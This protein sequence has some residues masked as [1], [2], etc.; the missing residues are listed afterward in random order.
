M[1]TLQRNEEQDI[2][3]FLQS[4]HNNQNLHI[5][6]VK[7]ENSSEGKIFFYKSARQIERKENCL[8][9]KWQYERNAKQHMGKLENVR[10]N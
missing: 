8:I 3:K 9:S 10:W 2:R 4:Y 7:I 1:Q 6:T 5:Y